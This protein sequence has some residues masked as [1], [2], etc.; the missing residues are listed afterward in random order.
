MCSQLNRVS[1]LFCAGEPS[2]SADEATL[3]EP[4]LWLANTTTALTVVARV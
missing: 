3:P 4:V 1:L 2:R